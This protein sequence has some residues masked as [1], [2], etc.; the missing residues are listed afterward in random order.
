MGLLRV[1]IR[2]KSWEVKGVISLQLGGLRAIATSWVDSIESENVF[3]HSHSLDLLAFMVLVT[4]SLTLLSNRR[5]PGLLHHLRLL[6]ADLSLLFSLRSAG[7]L[8]LAFAL[9][10]AIFVLL[11]FFS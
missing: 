1:E 5:S 9:L 3:H 4:S 7:A 2:G 8:P 11:A 10:R 6:P